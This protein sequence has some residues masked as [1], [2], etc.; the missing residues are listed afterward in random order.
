MNMESFFNKMT[1]GVIGSA[2]PHI[3]VGDIK[4]FNIMLPPVDAQKEFIFFQKQIDKSKMALQEM[5]AKM[6]ILKASVMQKYFC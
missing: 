6:E 4:A 5:K 1:E 3:N 2:A